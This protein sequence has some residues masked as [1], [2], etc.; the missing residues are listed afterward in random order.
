MAKGSLKGGCSSW[1]QVNVSVVGIRDS[2]RELPAA[3]E[4][5]GNQTPASGSAPWATLVLDG[6]GVRIVSYL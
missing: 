3:Q 4:H 6:Q 1:E 5:P 2:H